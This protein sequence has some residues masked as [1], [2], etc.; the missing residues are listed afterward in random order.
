M[1]ATVASSQASVLIRCRWFR[2]WLALVGRRGPDLR[3]P[4]EQGVGGYGV[5]LV[6]VAARRAASSLTY[7]APVGSVGQVR[8]PPQTE[9]GG[10]PLITM[11]NPVGRR[12]AAVLIAATLLALSGA[13]C[14]RATPSAPPATPP[15]PTTTAS[16][17]A[18]LCIAVADFRTATNQLTELDAVAVGLDGVKA[19]LQNLG[20]A[21]NELADAASAEFG[22]QAQ[23]LKEAISALGGTVEGL[24]NQADLSSKLG[25]IATS[26]GEVEQAAAAIVDSAQAGCSSNSTPPTT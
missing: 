7:E 1:Y 18:E 2:A 10:G 15:A 19:A 3:F 20:T 4:A 8:C 13:G 22:P 17:S 24:Q 9:I 23:D 12:A 14:S 16:T 26:V 6:G 25:E 21:A 5:L 11:S